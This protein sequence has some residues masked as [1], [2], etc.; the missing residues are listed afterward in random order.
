MKKFLAFLLACVMLLSLA[1]C[2][3]K[4]DDPKTDG[5]G[6]AGE[7]D[8][9]VP[10]FEF[11]QY[12]KG[13]VAIAGAELITSEDDEKLLRVY[14]DYTN[15]DKV[16]VSPDSSLKFDVVTQGEEELDETA[17]DEDDEA[18]V[19]EDNLELLTI[20]PGITARLT[21][22]FE[23]DPDG[24]KISFKLYLM[25]GSWMINKDDVNYFTFELDPKDLPGKPAKA[26]EYAKITSPKYVGS[27]K[28]SGDF[29]DLATPYTVTITGDSE[30]IPY[31][32]DDDKEEKAIRI[33]LTYK[34]LH[35][36]EWPAGV[37]LDLV[38]YQDG[39]SLD[40]ASDWYYEA[41]E[42]DE[43]FNEDVPSGEEIRC[44]AVF[45]L[46]N[47][48]PVEIVIENVATDT[49]VGKVFNVK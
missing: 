39:L 49:R 27:A 21:K 32:E 3:E 12:G 19:A 47:D 38:A 29:S 8:P 15:T 25:V 16:G 28:T 35:T 24:E 23:I 1:A 31:E 40:Y 33:G 5:A 9:N 42:E 30:V 13:R 17:I 2:G 37:V 20:Q 45:I 22:L 11:S 36:D 4:T 10:S 48:S 46:R 26:L 6:G 18:A 41:N 34:N 43:A 7:A 44:N 14:Y